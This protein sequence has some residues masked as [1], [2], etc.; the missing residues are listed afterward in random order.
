MKHIALACAM[1]LLSVIHTACMTTSTISTEQRPQNW[2]VA[3]DRNSN[4]Y[5]I[6]PQ[7]FRSDQ[8]NTALTPLLKQ[9]N[10]DVVINLRS[11]H[12]DKN[13]LAGQSF[14][15]IHI[16]I[17]TWAIDREDLLQVMRSIQIAQ[18]KHQ[19]VLIHCQHGSDRTG[20]SVAMYR[21]IFENWST[22]AALDEMKHGGYSFHAIWFNIEKIF[23]AENIK[24]IREQLSNPS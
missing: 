17:N 1:I 15:L 12:Q 5:Q 19:S 24:W 18:S 23:T 4:F 9:Y 21:I 8:P 7:L 10:I 14:Q 3:I 2:A 11:Q 22:Q 6:N 13:T 20:A 16:P